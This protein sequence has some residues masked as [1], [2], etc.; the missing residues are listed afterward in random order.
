LRFVIDNKGYTTIE[1]SLI[2]SIMMFVI[3]S[4]IYYCVIIY[5][6]A[7][8]QT[9]NDLVLSYIADNLQKPGRD[10]KTGYINEIGLKNEYLYSDFD[11]EVTN[12]IVSKAKTY[13]KQSHDKKS[14]LGKSV[15]FSYEAVI[16][17]ISNMKT[18]LTLTVIKKY[19][20]PVGNLL[21]IFGLDDLLEYKVTSRKIIINNEKAL[22]DFDYLIELH[23]EFSESENEYE[24]YSDSKIKEI[25]IDINNE[26]FEMIK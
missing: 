3:V 5:Q 23:N 22:N 21:K 18:E 16:N 2:V 19:R 9:E 8:I 13:L 20:N 15:S 25:F 24:A 14:L 4:A 7:L 12:Y 10:F 1:A 11:L 26:I 6:K 17:E